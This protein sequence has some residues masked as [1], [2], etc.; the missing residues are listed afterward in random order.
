[1]T[2][3]VALVYTVDLQ[4]TSMNKYKPAVGRVVVVVGAGVVVVFLAVAGAFVVCR[5]FL[6]I[7]VNKLLKPAESLSWRRKERGPVWIIY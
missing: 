5:N 4:Y 2:A 7:T 1:M 3:E 6:V